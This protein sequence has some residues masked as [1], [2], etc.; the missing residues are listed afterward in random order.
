MAS[1][2]R[3]VKPVEKKETILISAKDI[4]KISEFIKT[5]YGQEIKANVN[6]EWLLEK[7][8]PYFDE[9][10]RKPERLEDIKHILEEARKYQVIPPE[11]YSKYIKGIL[12]EYLRKPEYYKD[13][14]NL[15]KEAK[16]HQA[17]SSEDYVKYTKGL[18]ERIQLRA[19]IDSF[20]ADTTEKLRR[21]AESLIP[22][23]G[24]VRA[25]KELTEKEKQELGRI[26]EEFSGIMKNFSSYQGYLPISKQL[27]EDQGIFA[28]EHI[29][30]LRDLDKKIS[31]FSKYFD[32]LEKE[33][34]VIKGRREEERKKAEEMSKKA[35][36]T[37]NA[38]IKGEVPSRP[39][40]PE[41]EKKREEKRPQPP[42]PP[43]EEKKREEVSW[44]KQMEEWGIETIGGRE[45]KREEK[46][47]QP[48]TQ[49]TPPK[50]EEEKKPSPQPPV[51]P[52]EEKKP[53]G[54]RKKTIGG[55]TKIEVRPAWGVRKA[56]VE[57]DEETVNAI[58]KRAEELKNN[59][60]ALKK[61]LNETLTLSAYDEK[62]RK[63][64]KVPIGRIL[65]QL[66][67]SKKKS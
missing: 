37:F 55:S 28:K 66:E 4:P 22:I 41:E 27:V 67:S 52:K 53:E 46:R 32:A 5:K 29:E 18:S 34:K 26:R 65:K 42:A 49:P 59:K 56:R 35:E 24:K 13:I 21:F 62:G 30:K 63:T 58:L 36:E 8:K 51:P 60:A 9:Y 43:E 45:E 39:S 57:L 16:E 54:E 19:K 47:P 25:G 48:P 7:L 23:A 10:L 38:I 17:I 20:H 2:I 3:K 50:R 11:D 44:R 33:W 40:A 1:N 31:E 64:V 12:D 6:K 61:Y 14:M 15:L